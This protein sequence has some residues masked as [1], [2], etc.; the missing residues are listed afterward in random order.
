MQPKLWL[1][2]N[3]SQ[4]LYPLKSNQKKSRVRMRSKRYMED[5]ALEKVSDL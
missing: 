1:P 2:L 5:L 4:K 3:N